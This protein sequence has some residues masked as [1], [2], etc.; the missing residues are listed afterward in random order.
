MM[1]NDLGFLDGYTDRLIEEGKKTTEIGL[2]DGKTGIAIYLLHIAEITGNEKYKDI[3]SE[4]IGTVHEMISIEIPYYF[5]NGLLGIGCGFDYIISNGYAEGNSDVI[6]SD[7][8]LLARNIIDSRCISDFSFDKGV[9]GIGFYL[10]NRLKSR[11]ADDETMI[12]LKLKEYIIYLIDWIEELIMKITDKQE[13]NDAYFLL[14]RLQKL[15]IFNYKVEKLSS[16]C[17]QKM[18]D[19][20]CDITDNY[21]LLGIPSL[22]ILKL[23]I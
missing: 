11:M 1:D 18:I 22:K 8:D 16:I 5:D 21:D 2:W 4:F 12:D 15:N 3:A 6:L 7:I 20:N 13:Y 9:C 10:Y 19:L 23:W 17:L 14:T